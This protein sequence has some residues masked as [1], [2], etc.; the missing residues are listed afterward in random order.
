MDAFGVRL[1]IME[2]APTFATDFCIIMYADSSLETGVAV[3]RR[4]AKVH[5]ADQT[6]EE[7]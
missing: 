4:V 5:G 6:T 7:K 1:K 2:Q 3:S